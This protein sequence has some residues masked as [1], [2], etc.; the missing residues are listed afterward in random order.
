MVQFYFILLK[1]CL[2]LAII[3][4]LL[5]A[6]PDGG[7]FGGKAQQF[8]ISY[9]TIAISFN[10]TLTVLI[11]LRLRNMGKVMSEHMGN[12]SAKLYAGVSAILVESAAPYSILGVVFLIPYA[13]SSPTALAFSQIW[14]KFGVSP[15][16][17]SLDFY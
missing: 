9:Y 7:I 1:L 14:G 5:A 8:G 6:E 10:I 2:A 4:L 13:T 3:Q 17:L 12:E 16:T 15:A 11:V